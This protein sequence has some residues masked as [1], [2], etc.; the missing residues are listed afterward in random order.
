MKWMN[1]V[2]S[3]ETNW[4]N[5]PTQ[6]YVFWDDANHNGAVP[7]EVQIALCNEVGADCWFNMPILA[8]DD[9][10][11]Q[12]A[13]LAHSMLNS[14]L[15][16]YVEYGNEIWNNGAFTP[17]LWTQLVALGYGVFPNAGNDFNA[18]FIYGILRAVQDGATWKRVWGA[19]GARVVRVI[20]GQDSYVARNQYILGFT[21]G[22]YGGNSG[23]FSGTAAQNVDAFATGVY[24]GYPVP[25]T[26]TLDQLFTEIMSGGLVSGGYPGGMIKQALDQAAGDYSVASSFGL[27]MI[28]YEYGQTLY[29]PSG[30]NAALQTLYLAAMRDPRMGT[31]YTTYFN[32]WKS[33]GG[34]LAENFTLSTAP[35]PYYWGLLENIVQTSSP[36]YNAVLNFISANPCW[37]SG[38]SAAANSSGTS[39]TP[40]S[41]P[42]GLA[43]TLASATQINLSWTA[44]TDNNA[45]LAGYN[46]Y[47]NGTKVGTTASTSYSDTG[48]SSGTSYAYAVSAHDA[49]GNASA[50]S[51]SISV[52][53]P[54]P[55]AVTI[56]SPA[57][58]TLLKGATALKIAAAAIDSAGIASIA[59]TSGSTPLMTCSN[60][61]A[62]SAVM[63]SASISQGAHVISATATDKWGLQTSTSITIL[64]LK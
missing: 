26:F 35:N 20:A 5:R 10:V 45:A 1:T 11:T 17:N 32:G 18:G 31:A 57:N 55:P 64:S 37:W 39:T 63:A 53:T 56:S 59:I 36:K 48:L 41:V 13:T 4:A 8:T 9:Y 52:S 14:N 29:D 2:G 38:C 54:T 34:E 6:S 24:F 21:A 33:L 62:C 22:M 30:S 19:D 15:K 60:T 44:S 16:G 43:G 47:R 7:A 27:P 3:F 25:S 12:F 42:T 51:S 28:A 23:S 58:G 40:P 61:T 46:V 49:A 50:Q